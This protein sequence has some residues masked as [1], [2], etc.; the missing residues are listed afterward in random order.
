MCD[1]V[2]SWG[3]LLMITI[4]VVAMV[5]RRTINSEAARKMSRP[6]ITRVY[7]CF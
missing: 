3:F 7:T 4:V 2:L 6:E 5:I 1:S